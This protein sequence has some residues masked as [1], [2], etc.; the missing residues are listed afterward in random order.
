[1]NLDPTRFLDSMEG[2]YARH[3][4][5]AIGDLIVAM[6]RENFAAREDARKRLANVIGETMACGEVMGAWMMLRQ[7]SGVLRTERQLMRA[8]TEQMEA[9]ESQQTLLPNVTFREALE[10]MVS[11]TP[12]TLRDS[13]ERTAGRIAHMYSE[14]RTIAF[15]KAAE[16]AVTRRV[17]EL[18]IQ[19]L[20]E[21][22]G[23]GESAQRIRTEV[24]RVRE[25]TEPW[26]EAYARMA[27]RTN[28]N[29]AV[30]AGRFRM[31]Q[32]QDIRDLMPCFRFDAVGDS[33]TRHNHEAANGKIWRVDNPIWNKL[34][35]PLGYNCRC[36][37]SSVSIP[38]LRRMG[39]VQKDGTI[40]QDA[41][42]ADA[43]PDEGF[44]HT[45]RPDLFIVGT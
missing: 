43:F 44:R 19:A 14:G 11:R 20:R 30:T 22:I 9:F 12:K 3:Y 33:D 32:D 16:D 10:E 6:V 23:E 25:T 15:A 13:A 17:H 37:V 40:L 35:P 41:V 7:A 18:L 2:R 42:P 36:Q 29:T 28:V 45:G 4:T 8:D 34:A 21:G 38:Q 39:R 31:A 5:E 26:T 24:D 1:M 27:F